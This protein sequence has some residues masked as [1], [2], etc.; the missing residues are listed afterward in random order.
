M[1]IACPSCG[2]DYEVPDA[3]LASARMMRCA[4]C[5]HDWQTEAMVI[6]PRAAEAPPAGGEFVLGAGLVQDISPA[7]AT[8]GPTGA[9]EF[10]AEPDPGGAHIA[11][12]ACDA[13]Y[14]VPATLLTAARMMRCAACGHDWVT[15]PTDGPTAEE[16]W[17]G[18]GADGAPASETADAAGAT[19]AM[20]P[21][22]HI[23]ATA[24][25]APGSEQDIAAETPPEAMAGDEAARR[26]GATARGRMGIGVYLPVLLGW[27]VSLGLL[28]AAGQAF[29]SYRADIS[30]AWPPS[31]R[32]YHWI[33]L[34]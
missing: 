17:P 1:Q 13:V 14:E 26:F 2:A 18:P 9:E 12:P 6:E 22:A 34:G 21:M 4:A 31:Q 8:D 23:A 16:V 10:W 30:Q 25:A 24:G 7:D 15:E 19:P 29:L 28:Y 11:C 33:G 20:D 5:G 32:L 3:L 27:V